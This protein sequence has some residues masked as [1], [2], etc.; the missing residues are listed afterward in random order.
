[1]TSASRVFVSAPAKVNLCLHVAERRPDGYHDLESLVAFAVHGDE[2]VLE[3]AGA[4]SLS[5]VGP[6]GA[7]LPPDNDNLALKAARLLAD[8]VDRPPAVR[9]T[10][11]K[12]L[13]V[14][15]GLGGGSADAAAVLRGL[16]SLWKLEID[17]ETLIGIAALL[18]ADVPVC[19][20]CVAAWIDGRGEKI[21]SLSPLPEMP[22]LLVNPAVPV[23]TAEVFSALGARSGL[24]FVRPRAP[25][26][27]PRA[28]VAFLHSTT[29]DLEAPARKI[30][31]S[32]GDTLEELRDMPEILIARMSGS[33]ATCFGIFG[34][35]EFARSATALLKE[36]HQE[37][38]IVNTTIVPERI[39]VPMA[40]Q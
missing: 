19:L 14:A 17:R 13:P 15:S 40:L 6:F 8:K 24:K 5:A 23:S 39:G 12:N 4:L 31:P 28:L 26:R 29:N 35:D 27:D 32:I 30:A 22:L 9:I 33:G 25:F 1:V 2:I 20:D 3:H 36:R 21:T 10:L 16:A 11:R 18:G 37:W 7:M 38:W 34:S